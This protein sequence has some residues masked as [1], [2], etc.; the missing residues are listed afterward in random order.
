MPGI[1]VRPFSEDPPTI[2]ED[3]GHL[4]TTSHWKDVGSMTAPDGIA[5][6]SAVRLLPEYETS[7]RALALAE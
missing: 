3:P 1:H 5:D 2:L 4:L 6:M 7:A